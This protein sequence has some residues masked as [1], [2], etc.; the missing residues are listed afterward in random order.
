MRLVELSTVLL[1]TGGGLPCHSNNWGKLAHL[2]VTVCLTATPRVICQRLLCNPE[3]LKDTPL[4]SP[5]LEGSSD[6]E[7]LLKL[8]DRVEKIHAL[9]S[10]FFAK[11]RHNY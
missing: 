9:R 4:L 6:E 7:I 2:G 1:A 10:D 3:R 11:A 5:A 8:R